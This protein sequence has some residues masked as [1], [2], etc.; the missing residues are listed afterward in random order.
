M[1]MT[2]HARSGRHSDQVPQHLI[3]RVLVGSHAYGTATAASDRDERVVFVVPTPELFVVNASGRN[4]VRDTLWVEGVKEGQDLTGWEAQKFVQ[5]ALHCNPNALEVL[6]APLVAQNDWGARLRS[7]RQAFLARR[8]VYEA[9]RGY[10]MN[11]RLKMMNEPEVGWTR[12]NWKFAEAYLRALFQ[13]CVLLESGEL[14]IHTKDIDTQQHRDLLLAKRGEMPLGDVM[15]LARCLEE[16]LASQY[17]LST[18]P[19]VPDID[20]INHWLIDLRS[21]HWLLSVKEV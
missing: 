17:N 21:A 8:R 19:E 3:L 12:R 9:F 10:S 18:L 14:P 16:R 20:L 7:I 15:T 13:G 2:E 5:L 6:W 4:K 1:G 11:Q